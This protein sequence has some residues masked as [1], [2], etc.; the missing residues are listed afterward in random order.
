M[1]DY[2]LG[3]GIPMLTPFGKFC[4]K[5]RID[6]GELLKDMADKLDVTSSY[7]SAIENGKRNVPLRW[8][9]KLTELY[10]LNQEEYQEL[11]EVAKESQIKNTLNI[12]S[13]K[14]D[15]KDLL[16]ALA[17]KIDGMNS[18]DKLKI[19]NLLSKN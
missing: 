9:S 16:M 6:H 2:N 7:L 13:L 4:R 5:L 10:S 8:V 12:K 17:R 18:E 15:D 14:T 19:R 11:K 3:R 1:K